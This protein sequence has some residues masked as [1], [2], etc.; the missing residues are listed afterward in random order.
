M[1]TEVYTAWGSDG[2]AN[3]LMGGEGPPVYANG[4][5][6]PDCPDL[7]WRIYATSWDDACRQYHELQG[8]EPY[9]PMENA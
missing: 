2:R 7:I 6:Q 1:Q 3:T 9:K 5:L 8:W 4:T